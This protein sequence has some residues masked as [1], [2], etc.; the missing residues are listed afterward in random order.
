MKSMNMKQNEN[1]TASEATAPSNTYEEKNDVHI[2]FPSENHRIPAKR[3]FRSWLLF[4]ILFFCGAAT[5]G[6]RAD[7]L[8]SRKLQTGIAGEI[9]RFHVIANSD[10]EAD[11]ALK[12]TVRDALVTALAP[13][14]KSVSTLEEAR[15]VITEQM[16]SLKELAEAVVQ[17]NGYDYPVTVALEECYFPLKIY[18]DYTF[19]PGYYEALRV[20]I[21]EAGGRNWWC[22]MFPPLCFVDETYS[23]VDEESGEKLKT[24]LTEEE[25]DTLTSKKTPV[26]VKFKLLEALKDLFE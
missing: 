2:E 1:I 16:T 24:L 22:V 12:L 3:K 19:P 11:Q 13:R 26:K 7:A 6:I 25:Y 4:M 10:S 15:A 5:L 9:I 8:H 23:I 18:G 17:E 21:G 20:K 14:L